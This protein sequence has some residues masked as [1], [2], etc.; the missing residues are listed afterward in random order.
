MK[1]QMIY[2][3]LLTIIALSSILNLARTSTPGPSISLKNILPRRETPKG[4]IKKP[5]PSKYNLDLIYDSADF[6]GFHNIRDSGKMFYWG[7]HSQNNPNTAPLI[8]V[9]PEKNS[10]QEIFYGMGPFQINK[11]QRKVELNPHS[12]S[13][14]ANI[15]FIDSPV[16]MG[17]STAGLDR[18]PTEAFELAQ[19]IVEMVFAIP[20]IRP[21]F[22]KSKFFLYSEGYHSKV[23]AKVAKLVS[24]DPIFPMY[25]VNFSD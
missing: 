15:I 14:F 5:T 23:L 24:E 6:H 7:F 13:K 25:L 8:L 9:F 22:L 16:G 18:M 4:P 20:Y 2:G 11:R 17:L 12:W 19:N 10:V 3:Q 1:T 21:S